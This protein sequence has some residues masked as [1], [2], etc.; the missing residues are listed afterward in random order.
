[1]TDDT[2][3]NRQVLDCCR[4]AGVL[5]SA[6]DSN[7]PDGDLV[8]PAISRKQGLVISVATGGRSCRL[9]RVVKDRI[10]QLLDTLTN[11]EDS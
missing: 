11:E 1:M 9:A 7:W 10:A 8:M 2:D 3:V 5:C 6:A 4:A